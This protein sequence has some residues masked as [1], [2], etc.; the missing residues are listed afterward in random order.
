[1]NRAWI[2]SNMKK[3]LCIVLLLANAMVLLG[4]LW[5]EGA[6]P[7][8]H[9]VNLATLVANVIAFAVLARGSGQ[10]AS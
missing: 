7:F 3:P 9:T 8:A 1:V 10:R 6:P 5:P 2:P 4:M